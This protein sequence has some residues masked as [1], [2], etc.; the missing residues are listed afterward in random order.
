[1]GTYG[2]SIGGQLSRLER[3]MQ[4]FIRRTMLDFGRRFRARMNRER[5]GGKGSVLNVKTGKLKRSLEY[6]LIVTPTTMR[7]DA[8]IGGGAAPYAQD[9][10]DFGRLEFDNTFKIE[11]ETTLSEIA[12]GIEFFSR[13]P[14]ASA[15]GGNVTE[16]NDD[17]G[18]GDAGRAQL[19][20]EL[21]GHFDKKRE[22]RKL[23]RSRRWRS[24][25]KGA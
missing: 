11:S 16:K 21:R 15:G 17:G 5:I 19:L 18:G 20:S 10:E 7:I 23:S 12:T 1:M 4:G 13:N 14:S 22:A 8:Q 6:H 25:R 24:M 3:G 9:H 2:S